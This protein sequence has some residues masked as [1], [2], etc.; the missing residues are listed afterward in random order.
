MKIKDVKTARLSIPLNPPLAD[1]THRLDR[2]DWILVEVMTDGGL[3]GHSCM[4]SFDYGPELLM[5]IVDHELKKVESGLAQAP[6]HPGVGLEFKPEA[7][8][9][10]KVG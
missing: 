8:R 1:S 9:E 7:I 2:I 5:G 3:A 10:Y 4:L 6:S